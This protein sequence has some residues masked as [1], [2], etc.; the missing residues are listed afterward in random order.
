M[1]ESE[2]MVK[3]EFM[4]VE[5]I[6]FNMR[7]K[8]YSGGSYQTTRLHLA[9]IWNEVFEMQ[10]AKNLPGLVSGHSEYIVLIDVPDHPHRH[11]RILHS[12]DSG[13]DGDD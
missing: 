6:Y 4:N 12:F 10:I 7:G 2:H 11:P 1:S 5:L 13:E 3:D 8:Y 9:E